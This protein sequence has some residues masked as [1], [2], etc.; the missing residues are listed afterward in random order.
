[1]E[2]E[3]KMQQMLQQLLA[4]QEKAEADRIAD[5]ECMKQMNAKMDTNQTKATKQEEMLAEIGATMDINL[6]ELR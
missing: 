6:N 4:M 3:R 2:M 5:R 1:M